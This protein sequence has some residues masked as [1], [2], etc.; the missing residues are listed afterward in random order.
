MGGYFCIGGQQFDDS[1]LFWKFLNGPCRF[2][3]DRLKLLARKEEGP[4]YMQIPSRPAILGRQV[5]IEYYRGFDAKKLNS[6]KVLSTKSEA[7]EPYDMKVLC[8]GSRK[9]AQ[10]QAMAWARRAVGFRSP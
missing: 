10:A 2:R 1:A 3:D 8:H 4:W 6:V 9:A 7:Y 5:P